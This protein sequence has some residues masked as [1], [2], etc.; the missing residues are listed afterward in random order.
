MVCEMHVEISDAKYW[1]E[2]ALKL[3]PDSSVAHQYSGIIFLKLNDKDKA[4]IEFAKSKRLVE[5][6]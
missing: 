1:I 3:N 4:K 5:L 2:R 6:E